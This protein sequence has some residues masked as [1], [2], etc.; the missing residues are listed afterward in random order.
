[1]QKTNYIT[2]KDLLREIHNSKISYC[3]FLERKYADYDAIVESPEHVTP[4]LIEKTIEKKMKPRGR[5]APKEAGPAPT[6]EDLVFRVMTKEHIP[7]DPTRKRKAKDVGPL[8]ARTNFPPFKHYAFVDGELREVCRSHWRGTLEEG[9]FCQEHGQMTRRLADMFMLLVQRYALRGNFRGYTYNDEMQS[10]A[11]LQLSQVGL[12]F[13]ESKGDNPFAFYTTAIRNCFV[14]VLLV[15]RKAQSFRDDL[16]I[17][18][19]QTPSFTRQIESEIEQRAAW[20]AAQK[21]V[22][23]MSGRVKK[24]AR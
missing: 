15:E 12:Y 3:S 16:L 20:E 24:A 4:E 1:M 8:H 13:D 5:G 18:A 23:T 10:L 9:E 2:N 14:R 17:A 21:S 11:L 6:R 22:P 19:G 7:L